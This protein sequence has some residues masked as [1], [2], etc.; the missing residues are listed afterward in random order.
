MV[1]KSDLPTNHNKHITD[2]LGELAVLY[3]TRGEKWKERSYS[4]AV[5]VLKRHP[6]E[7][8]SW[9]EAKNLP[10]IGELRNDHN[11]IKGKAGK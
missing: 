1:G 9:E 10:C 5:A 3:K 11:F 4:K 7:I 2:M 8:T 6:K